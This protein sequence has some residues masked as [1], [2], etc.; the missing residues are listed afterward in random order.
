MQGALVILLVLVAVGLLLFYYDRRKPRSHS[1]SSG[2]TESSE[3]TGSTGSSGQNHSAHS[4]HSTQT[5]PSSA[6]QVCCGLH[7]V[8]E[9]KY[10][11]PPSEAPDYYDDEELD[12]LANR[13]PES[14]SDTEVEMLRD[15]VLTLRP[16][17]AWGWSRSLEQRNI[18]LPPEIRDELLLL[19]N[20]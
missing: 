3:S 11:A 8:C 19:L 2:S 17:D 7:A 6:P 14:Y 13:A 15:V 16:E 20:P 18:A 9:K 1:G 5:P 10:A 12:V 4:T